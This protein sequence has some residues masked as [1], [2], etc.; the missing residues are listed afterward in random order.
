MVF[1]DFVFN[2]CMT[3]YVYCQSKKLY[4]SKTIHEIINK[5]HSSKMLKNK[6]FLNK[7]AACLEHLKKNPVSTTNIFLFP[8]PPSSGAAEDAV[9]RRKKAAPMERAG[10]WAIRLVQSKTGRDN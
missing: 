7:Y 8:F 2:S 1:D 3:V 9:C 5:A 10:R 4:S 6:S